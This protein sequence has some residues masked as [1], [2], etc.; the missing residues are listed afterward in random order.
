VFTKKKRRMESLRSF[1]AV[2]LKARTVKSLG[3]RLSWKEEGASKE[4]GRKGLG[5]S[6]PEGGLAEVPC[7]TQGGG[8]V[9]GKG[10]EG[11]VGIP[12]EA[13]LK[14]K[15]KAEGRGSAPWRQHRLKRQHIQGGHR[16]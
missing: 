11:T 9:E 5:G 7:E 13:V 6:E 10:E 3:R 1:P 4:W 2:E 15:K 14:G 12:L 16:R 8:G